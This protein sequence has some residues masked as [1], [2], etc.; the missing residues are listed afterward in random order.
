[1]AASPAA[2]VKVKE[3]VVQTVSVRRVMTWLVPNVDST[4]LFPLATDCAETVKVPAG[5]VAKG[6]P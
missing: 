2:I 6:K 1:M 3:S 5:D 4:V